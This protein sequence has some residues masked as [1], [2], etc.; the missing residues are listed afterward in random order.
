MFINERN[1]Y[2]DDNFRRCC[3][4]YNDSNIC[5]AI[6]YSDCNFNSFI[7]KG[8]VSHIYYT[9]NYGLEIVITRVFRNVFFVLVLNKSFRVIGATVGS[10][11]F[12]KQHRA[13]NVS[14]ENS[15]KY[16]SDS[17]E[18]IADNVSMPVFLRYRGCERYYDSVIKGFLNRSCRYLGFHIE[19]SIK[20]GGTK[21]P[22]KKR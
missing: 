10:S 3:R 2:F 5:S 1:N 19:D 9:F 7:G 16:I 12:K 17:V 11:G 6:Y 20:Y 14:V 15:A 21:L 8:K 18:K 4:V 22:R 13:L